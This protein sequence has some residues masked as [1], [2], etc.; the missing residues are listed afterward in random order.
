MLKKIYQYRYFALTLTGF[1][2]VLTLVMALEMQ[3]RLSVDRHGGYNVYHFLF[4]LGFPLCVVT[5]LGVGVPDKPLGEHGYFLW[6]RRWVL[7]FHV[8][9]IQG[10]EYRWAIGLA[11]VWSLWNEVLVYWVLNPT[12][13]ADWDHYASDCL[14]LFVAWLLLKPLCKKAAASVRQGSKPAGE[15]S[16][17]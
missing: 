11:A 13:G 1:V 3:W 17:S 16:S 12:H 15:L 5:Q 7:A 2:V 9:N 8:E 6:L 14:G 4:G 10:L